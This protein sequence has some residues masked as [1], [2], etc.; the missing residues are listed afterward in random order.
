M[1]KIAIF[2]DK[3]SGH[4][5]H[6]IELFIVAFEKLVNNYGWK[7]SLIHFITNKIKNKFFDEN[8]ININNYLCEKLFDSEIKIVDIIEY[9][10]EDYQIIINRKK[11]N[12]T[13]NKAFACSIINFPRLLWKNKILQD[14]STPDKTILYSIRQNTTRKLTNN[15][16][17]FICSVVNKYE[18][19]ICD[20]GKKTISEQIELCRRHRCI[21]GVHGNNLS[22]IMWMAPHSYVFEILPYKD[23]HKVYDYHCMSLCMHQNY[24]Q[25]DCDYTKKGIVI[26]KNGGILL[27]ATIRM[28]HE[29]T[30]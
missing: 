15:S 10:P 17:K 2:L 1:F 29:L 16:H 25:I 3:F 5:F 18:G 20:L 26:S 6:D 21:I 24:T 28:I 4:L 27:L 23:K 7:S 14:F 12:S 9:N 19:T 8:I 11:L 30:R 22:G 13:I